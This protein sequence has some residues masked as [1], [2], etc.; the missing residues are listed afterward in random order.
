M[1]IG[2][3][4][5]GAVSI[6]DMDTIERSNLNRQFL[7]RNEDV[8]SMK[9]T[10]AAKAVKKMN[11]ALNIQAQSVRV[12]PQTESLY[13]DAFWESLDGVVTALDN[14]EARIYVDQRCILYQKPLIDSGTL[15]TKGSTQVIVPFLT[16]SY[17]SS[18]DAPEESI[19]IWSGHKMRG[20][21]IRATCLF[22]TLRAACR[23]V[24]VL[25]VCSTLKNFPHKIE[26]TIQWARDHF[27]GLFKSG[28]AEANNYLT[29]PDYLTELAKQQNVQLPNLSTVKSYLV[30][31]KPGDFAAC[32]RWARMLWEQEF[33][34]NIAQLLHNFPA[35][36]AT[37]EGQPFWSGAKRPPVILRFDPSDPLHMDFIVAASTLRAVNYRITPVKDLDLIRSV[38]AT[39]NPPPFVPAQNKKIAATEAEA[40]AMLDAVDDDHDAKVAA[41]IAALPTPSKLSGFHLQSIEFEKDDDTNEHIAFI[42]AC[43]NLR[44]RNYA[45]RESDR[46]ETKFTAGKIIP[47]IATTTAL[48]TG[49]VCLEIYKLL[50]PSKN[51]IEDFRCFSCNLALPI[52][53]SSEPIAPA[54]TK[55]TLKTGVWEWSLWDRIDVD[56]GDIT[57]E[58]LMS[59]FRDKYGLEL[60]ML[61]HGAS[62]IFYNFGVGLKKKVKDRLKEK[63]SDLV[64][65]VGGH[66]IKPEDRYLILEA[67]VANE[68]EEEVEI[69]SVTH[70]RCTQCEGGE[71]MSEPHRASGGLGTHTGVSCV[72]PDAGTCASSSDSKPGEQP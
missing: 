52:L 36:S 71:R 25:S 70:A 56:E 32:V 64:S 12:A 6:T 59:H 46:H 68:E 10:A 26:H 69:P 42:T 17:G 57:L 63:V 35:D 48:V 21:A 40:K 2:T 47:A 14:V 15:G 22:M 27:E 37:P 61:S 13:N 65:S 19:P 67:C 44:A 60:T 55:S 7:F 1:G 3:M 38:L 23:V 49:M 54:K 9:S 62:M 8:G 20:E 58:Q 30:D 45:I 51:R 18:R 29:Q 5:K 11:P 43:S 34:Y 50:Q 16:E 24:V 66:V 72:A 28:P 41:A 31:D 53:S 39:V 33:H 4:G